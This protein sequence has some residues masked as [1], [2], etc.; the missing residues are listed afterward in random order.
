MP[1]D[2]EY[3]R[4]ETVQLVTDGVGF[5]TTAQAGEHAITMAMCDTV[6]WAAR[7]A[8]V[9]GDDATLMRY[10]KKYCPNDPHVQEYPGPDHHTTTLP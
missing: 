5:L 6:R 4:A 1:T 7:R 9:R 10:L 3:W 2:T 8:H